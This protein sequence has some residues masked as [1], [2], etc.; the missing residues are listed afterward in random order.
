MNAKIRSAQMHKIPYML[1]IGDREIEADQVN[2]RQRDG[3]KPGAM[4]VDDFIALA[5]SAVTEKR[6]L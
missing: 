2:L 6:V 1:V 5:S 4:S 3:Q